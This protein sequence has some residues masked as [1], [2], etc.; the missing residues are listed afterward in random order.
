M[1]F[2]FLSAIC[3]NLDQSK[4]LSS[5]NGLKYCEIKLLPDVFVTL[6]SFGIKAGPVMVADAHRIFSKCT[7]SQKILAPNYQF[8]LHYIKHAQNDRS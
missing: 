4:I 7:P 6:L 1:Y 5:G 3:F 8:I 2:K